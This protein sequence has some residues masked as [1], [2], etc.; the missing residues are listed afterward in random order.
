[1]AQID[2]S[3]RFG[4]TA[5]KNAEWLAICLNKG[6]KR[7]GRAGQT[8]R[9]VE[10]MMEPSLARVRR[11]EFSRE[12]TRRFNELAQRH[13]VTMQMKP[14]R[15]LLEPRVFTLK[16]ELVPRDPIGAVLVEFWV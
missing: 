4:K 1:M 5:I 10:R 13:A 14:R 7:A 11:N 8:W 3:L 9:A 6:K 16:Q 12:T 15:S 2:Y